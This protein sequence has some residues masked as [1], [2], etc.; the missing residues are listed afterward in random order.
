MVPAS[1]MLGARSGSSCS[2][3]TGARPSDSSSI[4]QQLR[5]DEE[6]HAEGQHL[7]LA[8]GEVGRRVVEAL[9]RAPG[10]ARAPLDPPCARP[11]RDRGGAASRRRR[12]FS[13]HGERREHAVAAGHLHD[14][15]RGDLVR[16]G[17]GDLAPVEDHR[18]VVGLDHARDG[19]QQRR[20]AG[21]VRAEQRDD[22]A[23]RRPRGRRRTAPARRRR[24]TSRPRTS[25]SFDRPCRRS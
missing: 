9:R 4:M 23:L 16:R 18:A 20:L 2:T 19:L 10:T 1:R 21:A 25:S 6:R 24:T 3:T 8:A 22:L 5:P 12:R 11:R 15:E 17:V 13:A 14:A 7:L